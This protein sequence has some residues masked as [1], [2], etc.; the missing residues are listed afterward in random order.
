LL[1]DECGIQGEL[2]FQLLSETD[3]L[4][5]IVASMVAKLRSSG[6]WFQHFGISAFAFV[7]P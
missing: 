6:V 4:L 5:A 3:E 2:L 7:A 1:R